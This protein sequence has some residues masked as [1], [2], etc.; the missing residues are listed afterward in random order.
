M[1]SVPKNRMG[2]KKSIEE[3]QV[4]PEWYFKQRKAKFS[5]WNI[6]KASEEG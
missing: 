2:K 3:T 6:D 4:E 1:K 5:A